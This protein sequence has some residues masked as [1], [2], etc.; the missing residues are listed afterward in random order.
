MT[1]IVRTKLPYFN[2]IIIIFVLQFENDQACLKR[3]EQIKYGQVFP[4]VNCAFYRIFIPTVLLDQ[5]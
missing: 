1:R 3:H 4:Q 5:Y 2:S